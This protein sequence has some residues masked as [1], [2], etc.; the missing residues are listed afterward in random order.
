MVRESGDVWREIEATG[1]AGERE[2][3]PT[4]VERLARELIRELSHDEQ[5]LLAWMAESVP[6]RQIAEWTGASYDATAKRIQRLLKRVRAAA[7]VRTATWSD[8]DRAAL[9][10]YFSRESNDGRSEEA[11][12][13]LATTRAARSESPGCHGSRASPRQDDRG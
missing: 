9:A 6:Y 4:P 2:V 8:R 10:R 5:R 13:R 7:V 12:F 11:G 3:K 1:A